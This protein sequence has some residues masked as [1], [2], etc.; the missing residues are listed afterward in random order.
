MLF[1]DS[2]LSERALNDAEIHG[3]ERVVG[4]K[5]LSAVKVIERAIVVAFRHQS[6]S[7]VHQASSVA[8]TLDCHIAP[9]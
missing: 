9:Q 2:C 8:R 7:V 6:Q 1:G 4:R 5:S 3:E